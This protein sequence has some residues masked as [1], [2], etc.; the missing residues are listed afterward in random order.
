M[1]EKKPVKTFKTLTVRFSKFLIRLFLRVF[2][3]CRYH[4][5]QPLPT[6]GPVIFASNHLSYFDPPTVGA[7]VARE[8]F[9]LAKLE[10]FKNPLFGAL[11]RFYNAVPIRR[12]VMDWRAVSRLKEILSSDGT[13]L[14]FPEGTRSRDG[15]LGKGRFGVGLLSQECRATIVP[16]YVRGTGHLRDALLRRRPMAV[17]YGSPITP[18]QYDSFEHSARGQ[19]AISGLV[20]ERI[21]AMQLDCDT[22]SYSPDDGD[23]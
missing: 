19:L 22:G 12:E 11:I 21:A 4:Y 13:V 14:F 6:E 23:S 3:G 1:N 7:G 8:I 10:L 17:F 9:F 18:D 20:M 16:T 15:R 2:F 5:E